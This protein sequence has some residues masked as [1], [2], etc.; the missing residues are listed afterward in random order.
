MITDDD[1]KACATAAEAAAKWWRRALENPVFDNGEEMNMSTMLLIT[2]G[3]DE[4]SPET[5]DKFETE[6]AEMI[7]RLLTLDAERPIYLGVNYHPSGVLYDAARA[8]N[9]KRAPWPWK[10]DMHVRP[11]EVIVSAGY[12]TPNEVIW[13]AYLPA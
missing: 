6:L 12:G 3:T 2:A 1:I 5:L 9:M 8:A 13:P 4:Q 11:D 7:V 10:T